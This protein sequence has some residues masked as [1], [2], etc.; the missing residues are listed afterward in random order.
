MI[1]QGTF[2]RY[3]IL[4]TLHES[5]ATAVLLV[6]QTGLTDIR[7]LKSIHRDD[8]DARRIFR[9]ANLLSGFNSPELPTIYDVGEFNNRFYLVEEYI[10]GDTLSEYLMSLEAVT[11]KEVIEIAI[12]LCDIVELLHCNLSEPVIYRDLKPEHIIVTEDGLKLIDFGAAVLQSESHKVPGYGT[13]STAS[14]EQLEGRALDVRSDVY[15]LGMVIRYMMTFLG[16]KDKAG[17]NTIVMK[18]TN[19]NIEKRT[20]SVGELKKQLESLAIIY[21]SD[22]NGKGKHLQRR[23]AIVSQVAG[24]GVTHI[25]IGL[26]AYLNEKSLESFYIDCSQGKVLQKLY[27][28]NPNLGIKRGVLY[29]EYFRGLMNYGEAVEEQMPPEGV[30]VEDLGSNF[31]YVDADIILYVANGSFWKQPGEIPEFVKE[32]NCYVIGNFSNRL[33]SF[34]LAKQLNKRVYTYP[35]SLR[36]FKASRGEKKLFEKM[37][38]K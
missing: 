16:A 10:K 2:D 28:I 35:L 8:P 9:E 13:V 26:T 1:P 21:D 37:I 23:I 29:H 18:A 5:A 22:R 15:S 4:S 3:E 11:K 30:L 12:K 14:K 38:K 31:G 32:D 17:L 33:D 36:G 19:H 6:R 7:V 20:S 27:A 34:R 25:A 24:V